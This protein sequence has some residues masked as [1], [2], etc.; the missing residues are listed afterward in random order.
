MAGYSFDGIIDEVPGLGLDRFNLDA[1]V[2]LLT[3]C[4]AD[5]LV[6]LANV[7]FSGTV[8]CS[9]VTRQLVGLLPQYRHNL[10]YIRPL[11]PN[12]PH[13]IDVGKQAVKLTLLDAYHCPGAVMF[14]VESA[15][16]A[17]LCTGDLRA[18]PWWLNAM[19]GSPYLFPY[20][21]GM[22][23]LEAIYLDTTFAYRGEPYIEMLSNLEGINIV[24]LLLQQY[25][26]DDPEVQF[27]FADTTLGFEEVWLKIVSTFGH[28]LRVNGAM[29]QKL[30]VL[31]GA[32]REMVAPAAAPGVFRVGAAG[33]GSF[34]VHIRQC[35]NFNAVDFAGLFCPVELAQAQREGIELRRTTARG[36]RIYEYRGRQWLLPVG[37]TELLSSEIK[38]IFSRHSSYSECLDLVRRL[39][40]RQVYPC[41]ESRQTWDMGFQMSRVFG[42][43]SLPLSSRYDT[44]RLLQW[45]PPTKDVRDRPVKVIDRWDMADCQRELRVAVAYTGPDRFKMRGQHWTSKFSDPAYSEDDR[46]FDLARKKDMRLQKIVIG[47]GERAYRRIIENLQALYSNV[48]VDKGRAYG[49]EDF[50]EARVH[51]A[52]D[53]AVKLGGWDAYDYVGD[54]KSDLS[55]VAESSVEADADTDVD[56]SEPEAGHDPLGAASGVAAGDRLVLKRLPSSQLCQTA[57]RSRLGASLR[58]SFV[59]LF[60]RDAAPLA[61]SATSAT[62]APPAPPAPSATSTPTAPPALPASEPL[63][64]SVYNALVENPLAW[65]TMDLQSAH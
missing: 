27:S 33:A 60:P 58:M 4:H 50:D 55:A 16:H 20:T 15:H 6:G 42:V 38:L 14:L 35:V 9:P 3:H 43:H 40:P 5:H 32:Y 65:L 64:E 26:M 39:G 63:I 36:H 54:S 41:V 31:G 13:Q 53:G 7:N 59:V 10:H 22:K 37:G 48:Y 28:R 24:I 51:E 19:V 45:G 49:G 21:T 56:E 30:K 29:E 18:E 57:K 52:A 12:Q 44:L 25:P 62:S 17:V 46:R 61:P 8:Y 11:E 2:I 34:E 1:S 23:R 47:R